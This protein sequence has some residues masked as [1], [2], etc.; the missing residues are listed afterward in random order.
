[1]RKLWN[2]LMCICR[3]MVQLVAQIAHIEITDKMWESLEQFIK[4]GLVGCLNAIVTLVI[5]DFIIIV[6][7]E[8][9][10]LIAQTIGYIGGIFN[11]YF[12]NSRF[13]FQGRKRKVNSFA[14]MCICYGSTYFIQMGLLYVFVEIFHWSSFLAP[15]IAI[16]ITTPINFVLNKMWAFR[17]KKTEI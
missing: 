6:A 7:G 3:M 8:N 12:W 16:I 13:V 14:K 4:F 17:V 2:S 1:M 5:Y 10:Y 9:M 11:S 15:I